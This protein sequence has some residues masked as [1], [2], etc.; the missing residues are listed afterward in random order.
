MPPFAPQMDTE[1]RYTN[2]LCSQMSPLRFGG[3]CC[4]LCLLVE[5][6]SGSGKLG[7][8]GAFLHSARIAQAQ[9]MHS[10]H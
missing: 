9:H 7:V 6:F 5:L 3:V 2:A 1:I 4:C 8:W 10:A